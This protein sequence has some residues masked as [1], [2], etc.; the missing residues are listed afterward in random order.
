MVVRTLDFIEDTLYFWQ[1]E[2]TNETA[3]GKLNLIVGDGKQSIYRWRGGKA[4]HQHASRINQK[5][6]HHFSPRRLPV[7]QHLGNLRTHR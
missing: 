6:P 7:V 5:R 2:A 3:K 1:I 4:E